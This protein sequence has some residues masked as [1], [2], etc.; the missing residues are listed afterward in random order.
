MLWDWGVLGLSDVL[1]AM[2]VKYNKEEFV[3]F[4]N[5]AMEIQLRTK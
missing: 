4:Y 3:D 1:G 2:R 5:R